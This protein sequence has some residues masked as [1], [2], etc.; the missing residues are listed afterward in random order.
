[1]AAPWEKYASAVTPGTEEPPAGPWSKYA[2]IA[3]PP[4]EEPGLVGKAVDWFTGE[5]RETEATRELPEL[6]GSGLLADQPATKVAKVTYPLLFSDDPNEM[7]Q[8][9]KSN[10]PEDIAIKYDKNVET[11]EIFPI[12]LNRN[13]GA[14]AVLNKPG[15][16]THDV[17]NILG[18]T[19]LYTAG[20]FAGGGLKQLGAQALKHSPKLA[21]RTAPILQKGA[22]FAARRPG[23]TAGTGA[24][25]EGAALTSGVEGLQ[26]QAGGEF[27]VENVLIDTVASFLPES[28]VG[29]LKGRLGKKAK[30]AADLTAEAAAA[31]RARILDPM[32]PETQTAT[33]TALSEAQQQVGREADAAVHTELLS[34]IAAAA[35]EPSKLEQMREL[36]SD[37][38]PDP[39]I[40]KAAEEL[41]LTDLPASW[42]SRNQQYIEM[43][44][45]LKGVIGSKLSKQ[46]KA[47][48]IEV[49]NKADD[50][51][52]EFGGVQRIKRHFLKKSGTAYWVLLTIWQ[53]RLMS[54]T[55]ESGR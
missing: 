40:L 35:R 13:T 53:T 21:A 36:P 42:S 26:A 52:T 41:G 4:K 54:L 51:I 6:S 18:L 22:E 15:A 28:A 25:V 48:L 32:S 12:A 24:A 33:Q 44:Q 27:D 1:M 34:D 39:E 46:E 50:L 7:A 8:I 49:K 11:G 20:G 10:F 17:M 14:R 16:S 19:G 55:T 3:E 9:L 43:E 47:K 23:L 30:E 38:A 29:W 5:S 45:G 2:E 31:E 37:V